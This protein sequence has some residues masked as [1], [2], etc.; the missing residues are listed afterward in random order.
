MKRG[1]LVYLNLSDVNG[2]VVPISP[3]CRS[4]THGADFKI[5]KPTSHSFVEM[6]QSA[7]KTNCSNLFDL[8][9]FFLSEGKTGPFSTQNYPGELSLFDLRCRG[10]W[11]SMIGYDERYS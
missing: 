11:S 1:C 5:A 7:G 6:F 10:S 8:T 3:T 2:L 4:F 9:G